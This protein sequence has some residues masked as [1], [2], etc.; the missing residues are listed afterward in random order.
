MCVATMSHLLAQVD[1]QGERERHGKFHAGN[2][3]IS[4]HT[5]QQ[6]S[7][8]MVCLERRNFMVILQRYMYFYKFNL[9]LPLFQFPNGTENV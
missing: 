8:N 5:V 2:L 1:L 6:W 7:Q 3:V 9:K 4:P